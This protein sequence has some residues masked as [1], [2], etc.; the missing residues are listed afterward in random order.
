MVTVKGKPHD[1]K[2]GGCGGD[3]GGRCRR[4]SSSRSNTN[5]K[6]KDSNMKNKKADLLLDNQPPQRADILGIELLY[7]RVT[8]TGGRQG[9]RVREGGLRVLTTYATPSMI[10]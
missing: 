4:H 9:F 2:D 3:G 7:N 8:A 6:L 10:Q 5:M 1:V